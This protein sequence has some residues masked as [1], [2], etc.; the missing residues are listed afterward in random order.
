MLIGI[1]CRRLEGVLGGARQKLDACKRAYQEA[2][3][4]EQ[5]LGEKIDTAQQDVQGLVD[6]QK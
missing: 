5:G 4:K 3:R 2:A 6:Q 1:H